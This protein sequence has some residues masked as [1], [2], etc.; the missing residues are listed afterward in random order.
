MCN[1]HESIK[2]NWIYSACNLFPLGISICQA[3]KKM[4]L[5]KRQLQQAL[6]DL[7]TKDDLRDL[8]F[9]L[10]INYEELD[11]KNIST[12]TESLLRYTEKHGLITELLHQLETEKPSI[13]WSEL[14]FAN[15]DNPYRGLLAFRE[16]D[17]HLFFGRDVYVDELLESVATHPLIAVI[18]PSG[19]G[20]SSVV[21]AGLL[22]R[23]RQTGKWQSLTFH[24]DT[25]PFNSLAKAIILHLE[26][27]LSID[28]QLEKIDNLTK[29]LKEKKTTLLQLFNLLTDKIQE[30]HR[31]LLIIDQFEE[32][33]TQTK[34]SAK[35]EQFLDEL[36]TLHSAQSV[37]LILTMRADFLGRALLH[38]PFA[39]EL[40]HATKMIGP[41]NR[42]ELTKVIENPLS[43]TFVSFEPGLTTQI[44]DDVGGEPGNLPLLEFA[45]EL[46]WQKQVDGKLTFA[47]YE[48]MGKVE[49]ALTKHRCK[50]FN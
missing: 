20:K 46:L 39:D 12:I 28:N 22:P 42:S 35:Q 47:S 50:N 3:V 15:V 24:P 14:A 27:D 43:G 11:E 4:N 1:T 5:P 38:R 6:K 31:L 41:M 45:L 26:P 44:L 37:T 9:G 40:Q 23:L 34:E 17:A 30:G 8:S 2:E 19:S 10:G 32:L 21:F 16:E 7:F 18:G 25:D 36:L 49:G 29:N 13:N 33:Y 48:Q